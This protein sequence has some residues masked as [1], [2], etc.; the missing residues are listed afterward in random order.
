[1]EKDRAA[2]GEA[3]GIF[4]ATRANV[5]R[6]GATGRACEAC[7][8]SAARAEASGRVELFFSIADPAFRFAPRGATQM[9]SALQT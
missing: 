8:M 9:A 1:M 3:G 7:G 2:A 6:H 5:W 4:V